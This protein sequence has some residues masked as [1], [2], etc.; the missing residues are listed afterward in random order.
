M[1]PLFGAAYAAPNKGTTIL[2]WFKPPK[3]LLNPIAYGKIQ[4]LFKAFWCF[5]RQILF[6]RTFQD[7]FVYSSTFQACVNPGYCIY[8]PPLGSL[9]CKQYE[10]W[11]DCFR[12]EKCRQTYFNLVFSLTHLCKSGLLPFDTWA[13]TLDFQQCGMCNQQSLRSPWAYAQSDQSLC[14]SLEYS[15]S[16]KLLTEHHLEFLILKEGCTGLSDCTLVK[17]PHCWKTHVAAH[18]VYKMANT[19]VYAREAFLH[20]VA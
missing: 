12:G 20:G 4:G 9:Y 8:K 6:S 10:P 18:I 7:S 15:M 11:S 1:V 14:L 17:M 13:A 5:S 2:Y 3:T 16:V 19:G